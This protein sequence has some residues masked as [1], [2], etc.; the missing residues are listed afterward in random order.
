MA[1]IP[2]APPPQIQRQLATRSHGKRIALLVLLI[3]GGAFAGAFYLLGTKGK[4]RTEATV[5]APTSR[6]WLKQ[7]ETY[8]DP[9]KPV[10]RPPV[11]P[12]DTITPELARLR[13][14]LLAMKLKMD[15]LDKRKSGTTVVHPQQPAQS[16]AKPPER[17]PAPMLYYHKDLQDKIAPVSTGREYTLAPWAT[18]LPCTIEPL[19]NSDVE[20]YF[21]AKVNTNVYDTQT[22]HHLLIPQGATIGGRDHGSTLLYGNERLPTTSLALTIGDRTYDLGQAPMMDHLGTNGLTG[23]VDQHYWRLFGAI[24]IGGALRG[25]QQM[26]Q[27]EMAQAG[28]AGQIATGIAGLGNQAAS[29]R[30][31]RALDT[32]PTIKVFP[33]QQCQVLLIKE[34]KLPV[35]WE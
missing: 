19:M 10:E 12:V 2:T 11:Q 9:E 35:M 4:P 1:T 13:N 26:L 22:G 28:G 15:E 24:F 14:E 34:L 30:I 6:P 29:Q 33:G 3:F 16:A 17:R 27:M 18:K 20:G 8:P 23:E 21:T 25:G 7:A 5:A 31:G 32:R